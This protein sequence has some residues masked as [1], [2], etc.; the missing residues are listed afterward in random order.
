MSQTFLMLLSPP[1][2]AKLDRSIYRLWSF[3]KPVR[4]LI[5]ITVTIGT[6]Q[7]NKLTPR[8]TLI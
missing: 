6:T 4:P 3:C 8:I 2:N 5:E 1:T 7:L